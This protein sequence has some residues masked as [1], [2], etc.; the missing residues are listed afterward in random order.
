MSGVGAGRVAAGRVLPTDATGQTYERTGVREVRATALGR[1]THGV[2]DV[3][4]LVEDQLRVA[5]PHRLWVAGQVGAVAD[6]TGL[7]GDPDREGLRFWLHAATADDEPFALH[8][9]VEGERLPA[10]RELL[11]HTHDAVLPDVVR[12]GRLACVGGLVRLE[13]A[14]GSVVLHVSELD[15]TPTSAA[16]DDVR[17]QAVQAVL[18]A[19]LPDR[20]R[21]LPAPVAP[22]QVAVVGPAGSACLEQLEARFERA[23]LRTRVLPVRL[24]GDDAPSQLADG[25]RAAGRRSDVVLLVRDQGQPLGLAWFD[26]MAA[27][28]AVADSPVPLVTGLGGG[29][30]R[31]ACDEVA[32]AVAPTA[33]AAADL[34][35][36]WRDDADRELA[37]LGA[38]LDAAAAEAADRCR[39][40][41]ERTAR[42]VEQCGAE[43]AERSARARRSWRLRLL[44][45]CAL[46]AAAAVAVAAV[47][48]Q[49][50]ALLLLVLPAALLGCAVLWARTRARR[51]R[52]NRMSKRADDFASVLTRLRAV[53]TEL[54]S[55]SSPERV[56]VLREEAAGLLERGRSLLG[57]HLAPTPTP[58]PTPARAS[59]PT[60]LS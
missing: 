1:G 60:A 3:R 17:R 38:N 56:A 30:E 6:G 50:L 31:T 47:A 43:A 45:L 49:P 34:V 9:V 5:F 13:P 2:R 21:R 16:L 36:G 42:D 53:H 12:P 32:F 55:T 10:V 19:G 28:Q 35:V 57:T 14:G 7:D 11:L 22:L 51:G 18:S 54:T 44:V 46:L 15:P 26:G 33:E 59:T 23:G 24:T 37:R 29:G 8:C 25:L 41:L 58:A 20:Q 48:Q 4:R 39:D 52:R 27:A 40:D